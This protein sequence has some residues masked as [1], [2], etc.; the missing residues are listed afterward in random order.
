MTIAVFAGGNV[1]VNLWMTDGTATGTSELTVS[2]ALSQGLFRGI[3]DPDFTALGSKALFDGYDTNG[4]LNL[5][6]TDATASGTS[7][8]MV[9]GSSSGGL[10]DIY[11]IRDPELTVLGSKALFDGFDAN[12]HPNLWVTDGTSAGTSELSAAGAYSNG[13]LNG[14]NPEFT[15]FG[16]RVLFVGED[17]NGHPN[18]W[19]TDGT[20]AGTSELNVAGAEFGGLFSFDPEPDFTAVG[21][22]ILF[23]GA[24]ANNDLVTNGTSAG[25]IELTVT[26]ANSRG[27]FFSGITSPNFTVLGGKAV[28][29]G[30]DAI[31]K[32]NLWVT[33]G[34][35]AGTSELSVAGANSRGLFFN[36][37]NPDF[38][39]LGS[40]AVFEGADAS[41]RPNLWVTDGTSAGTSELNVAGANFNGLFYDGGSVPNPDFTI[42]GNEVL[43]GG[44]DSNGHGGLWVT[45]GTSA[46]TSELTVTDS[47]GQS[48]PSHLTFLTSSPTRPPSPDLPWQTDGT[49][50]FFRV[51]LDRPQ[52][53]R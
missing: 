7:E 2:G 46:G 3:V 12:G 27:V 47:Y 21:S 13:L 37:L 39:V 50:I 52:S 29:E 17:A 18:L 14:A 23:K 34:T 33:D 51:T 48:G 30:E 4:I 5:W 16:S 20:S 49:S 26:G 41:G 24:D 38:T 45:D 44:A 6:V 9:V 28:F 1:N 19:V 22:K 42:H 25:T 8:L 36:S 32:V 35:S 31:G 11:S 10:F 40:T 53:G 15:V 43:F